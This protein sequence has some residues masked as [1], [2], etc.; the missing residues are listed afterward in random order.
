MSKKKVVIA[1]GHRALGTTM[2]EQYKATRNTAKAIA[3]LVE[4]KYQIVITH[5]NGPQVGMIQTAMTEF[6][7]LNPDDRTVAPMSVCGAMSE[8]YIGYDLQNAI[9][10]ELLN[11]GIYKTVS[12]II[13]Q[14]RVDPFDA[15][16]SE[17]SKIIGRFMSK[18]EAEA[19][20]EKGNHVVEEEP[21]KFR[22]IIAAPLPIDIYEIDAVKA[23][24][25]ADQIV[26]AAGG[27]GIPV[28]QQGTHLKGAS[29][30]IEK[31]YTAAKLAELV[32]AQTLLFLTAYDNLTIEKGTPNEKVFEQ[33][34]AS[35]LHTYIK[36]GHFPAK[37][38]FPK[39]DAS[40]RFVTAD[41]ERKAVISNLDKAKSS[42]AGK[43][44][45]TITA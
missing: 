43:T 14:V 15:A 10:E 29:A 18:E 30:I 37:T 6:A 38:T 1:L 27:G 13:T 35:D 20:E 28:L 2:P 45:T 9:R 39:V 12:T 3:D 26:I 23:L 22:R 17:P 24:L 44:G 4:E 32:N 36:A 19:E 21:G 31:D 34:S 40:I 33:V 11:R 16:F 41:S 5:S 7:R 25:D 8:G 42:L